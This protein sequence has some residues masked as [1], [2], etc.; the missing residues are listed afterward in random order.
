[1]RD[2]ALRSR[3]VPLGFDTDEPKTRLGNLLFLRALQLLKKAAIHHIAG[4]LE[5]PFSALSKFLPSYQAALQWPGVD[6]VRIDSC[7]YGSI[8]QKS[9]AFLVADVDMKS[10]ARRCQGKCSHVPIAGVYTKASAI[11]TPELAAALAWAIHHAIKVIKYRREEEDELRVAGLENQLV[12]EVMLSNSCEVRKSWKFKR[13]SHINLLELKSVERLAEDRAKAGPSRF[14]NFVD[15]NVTRCALGKGRSA[16][17]ALSAVLRRISAVMVAFGLYM[18]TP[19]C[20]T[21]SNCADDPTTDKALRPPVPG[22]GWHQLSYR[23]LWKIACIPPTRRWAS[24]WIR[25]LL[26]MVGPRLTEF[27]DR[28]TF[29]HRLPREGIFRL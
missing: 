27:N 12:N 1:M 11:Y 28:T 20:P 26:F 18:V 23:E 29:R 10:I 22:L 8:H 13:P 25:L 2:V 19:F 21:R 5:R 14:V 9:F 7:Q 15:S 3:R 4:L 6:E 16:S 24:N 17:L